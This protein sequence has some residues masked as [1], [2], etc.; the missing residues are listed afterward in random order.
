LLL[1]RKSNN[2]NETM[3]QQSQTNKRES[4]P[5]PPALNIESPALTQPFKEFVSRGL[6]EV[7]VLFG[8][9]GTQVR[10]VPG[11]QIRESGEDESSFLPYGVVRQRIEAKGLATPRKGRGQTSGKQNQPLPL[12]SL[13]EEDFN[14]SDDKLLARIRAV[15]T[16]LGPDVA[17]SRIMTLQLN[18]NGHDDFESWWQEAAASTRA[19]LLVDKKHAAKIG[20]KMSKLSELSYPC[21]FRGSL[22]PPQAETPETQKGKEKAKGKAGG[23]PLPKANG[24]TKAG[25]SGTKSPTK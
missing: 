17:R 5:Q 10:C 3:S 16:A 25:T 4:R 14:G 1:I 23:S 9:L 6:V 19:R 11:P 18:A 2:S 12:K 20:D 24:T 22:S 7:H 15:A 21:P 13:C 8:P